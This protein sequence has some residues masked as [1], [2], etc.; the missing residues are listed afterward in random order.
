MAIL[1]K[2][3]SNMVEHIKMCYDVAIM[4]RKWWL[5]FHTKYSLNTM[6]AINICILEA[7]Y[8]STLLQQ[9]IQ[10]QKQH[11]KHAHVLLYFIIFSDDKKQDPAT[12]IANSKHIIELFNQRN[13]MY[14][15]LF[16]L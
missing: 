14:A 16:T 6:E 9:H 5:L 10:K 3:H 1:A 11:H 15:V 13:F 8:W 4:L 2:K 12:T 7:L